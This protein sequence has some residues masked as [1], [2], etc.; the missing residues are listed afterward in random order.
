MIASKESNKSC[1]EDLQ[2]GIFKEILQYLTLKEHLSLMNVSRTLKI[3]VTEIL[4]INIRPHFEWQSYVDRFPLK[5]IKS[6]YNRYTLV[7]PTQKLDQLTNLEQNKGSVDKSKP[8]PI[9]VGKKIVSVLSCNRLICFQDD[10]HRLYLS[11]IEIFRRFRKL[12]SKQFNIVTSPSKKFELTLTCVWETLDRVLMYLDINS[13]DSVDWREKHINLPDECK[14]EEIVCWNSN[15]NQ[16][17]FATKLNE[18]LYKIYYSGDVFEIQTQNQNS[19]KIVEITSSPK[20]VVVSKAKI[21]IITEDGELFGADPSI[22]SFQKEHSQIGKLV[23]VWSNGIGGYIANI[24]V[25]IPKVKDWE[26]ERLIEFFSL[27]GLGTYTNTVKYSKLTGE[28]LLEMDPDDLEGKLGIKDIK[29]QNHLMLYIN[30]AKNGSFGEP[31]LY[32]WGNNQSF[33]LGINTGTNNVLTPNRIEITLNDQ[34]DCISSVQLGN[35]P[36]LMSSANMKHF[37]AWDSK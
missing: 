10:D 4:S 20:S 11:D 1:F 9:L 24:D 21:Y 33:D 26:N 17:A 25:R 13:K 36:S 14:D 12:Q 5:A 19:W 7:I 8:Q 27:I 28:K 6:L 31:K 32:G 29:D 15:Y 16:F 2:S 18:S 37:I 23:D 34:T 35:G 3:K 22:Y 30:L